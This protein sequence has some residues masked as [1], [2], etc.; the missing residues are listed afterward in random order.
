MGFFK[1]L[2]SIENIEQDFDQ[3]SS[4]AVKRRMKKAKKYLANTFEIENVNSIPG[5]KLTKDQKMRKRTIERS[6]KIGDFEQENI[7]HLSNIVERRH[8]KWNPSRPSCSPLKVHRTN[9]KSTPSKLFQHGAAVISSPSPITISIRIPHTPSPPPILTPST[10]ISMLY[11]FL[12]SSSTKHSSSSSF[13]MC[14]SDSDSEVEDD[15]YD[16]VEP[17][18]ESW[19]QNTLLPYISL[20]STSTSI[21]SSTSN[22]EQFLQNFISKKFIFDIC[23]ELCYDDERFC[24][25]KVSVIQ[26]LYRS[27]PSLRSFVLTALHTTSLDRLERCKNSSAIAESCEMDASILTMRS[28]IRINTTFE[29][30][31]NNNNNRNKSDNTTNNTTT[32]IY[33]S[34]ST[35]T[36]N[37]MIFG[38][39]NNMPTIS[40]STS[41]NS[42]SSSCTTTATSTAASSQNI[43]DHDKIF[44]TSTSN[45]SSNTSSTSTSMIK[46]AV[47]VCMTILR[48]LGSKLGVREGIAVVRADHV[49]VIQDN[50]QLAVNCNPGDANKEQAYL[51]IL[52]IILR[53]LATIISTSTSTSTSGGTSISTST[54]TRG[55][56]TEFEALVVALRANRSHWNVEVRKRSEEL[57]DSLVELMD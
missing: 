23:N 51:T 24:S 28:I 3:S 46:K 20:T 54:S 45:T 36:T 39:M 19:F 16:E 11:N 14:A 22:T 41:T 10:I 26:T 30:N 48:C 4:R 27:F 2:E 43:W 18:N 17:V 37:N 40:S 8:N 38:G 53:T 57:F 50:L 49:T 47:S 1:Q 31:K 15:C 21:P 6:R 12:F 32:D 9:Q 35:N 42:S 5:C 55:Y 56:K 13:R 52:S 25:S 33:S 7:I 29:Y 44:P 34:S